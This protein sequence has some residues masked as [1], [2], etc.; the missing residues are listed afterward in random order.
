MIKAAGLGVAM[1]NATDMV[2]KAVD[3]IIV[4]D[5]N[6]DGLEPILLSEI[7]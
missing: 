7:S 5:N 3:V 6:N 4:S 2:K 1:L